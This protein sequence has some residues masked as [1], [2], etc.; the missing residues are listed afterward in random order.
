[1]AFFLSNQL[2]F[3]QYILNKRHKYGIKFYKLNFIKRFSH[4]NGINSSSIK[5]HFAKKKKTFLRGSL[6]TDRSFLLIEMK[7]KQKESDIIK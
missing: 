2:K 3:R 6:K 5:N 4:N 1:M 7:I